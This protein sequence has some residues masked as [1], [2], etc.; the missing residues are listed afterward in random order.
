MR[1][2]ERINLKRVAVLPRGSHTVSA[3]D[4]APQTIVPVRYETTI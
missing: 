1:P 4:N 2:V 3:A